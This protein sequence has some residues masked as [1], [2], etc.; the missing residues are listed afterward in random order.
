MSESNVEKS[1]EQIARELAEFKKAVQEIQD[2]IAPFQAQKDEIRDSITEKRKEI[3]ALNRKSLGIDVKVK[4]SKDRIKKIEF[5]IRR[6]E[7]DFNR[8]IQN[9]AIRAEFER[10]KSEFEDV[11]AGA[12]WREFALK[13]Q[14]DGGMHLAAAKRGILGDKPGLGKTLTSLIWADMVKAKKIIVI[15]PKDTMSNFIREVN[16]WAPHRI[17]MPI[18]GE[19]R[20]TR[21]IV[22]NMLKN[23]ENYLAL[24]NYDA[25]RRD[26]DMLDD[27]IALKADTIILDEAHNMKVASTL[28]AR[29]IRKIVLTPNACRECGGD[30]RQSEIVVGSWRTTYECVA[31]GH[32]STEAYEMSSIRNVL[33]M[34]GTPI[35]NRPQDLFPMLNIVDPTQFPTEK[36]FLENYCYMIG[37]NKWDFKY[38][39]QERLVKKLATQFL[40]RTRHDAGIVLP[41]QDV[42]THTIQFDHNAYPKQSQILRDLNTAAQIALDDETAYGFLYIIEL[43]LRKRQALVWPDGIRLKN[44]KT[45]EVIFQVDVKESIKIDYMISFDKESGEWQGLIPD[46]VGWSET[47]THKSMMRDGE[48]IVAFSQF[49]EPMHEVRRRCEAAGISVVEFNGETPPAIAE[50]VKIDID[51][52]YAH[53]DGR[54]PKYQVILAHYRKGGEGLNMTDVSQ[55]I[56]LDAPWNPAGEEQAQN[57][58]DRMGQ[59][60]ETTVHILEVENSIDTWMRA[61]IE[62][63]RNMINGFEREQNIQQALINA[64]RSGEIL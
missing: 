32:Q 31:C 55:M 40:V 21:N 26:A 61:I 6:K 23:Q 62:A 51:K 1:A 11:I 58:I 64:I 9:E 5:D 10:A 13:H 44:P 46:L 7:R 35:I 63:K 56:I 60:Q 38:G 8:A 37:A 14:V 52:N 39:G 49:I 42:Q 25:W 50:D 47:A 34:T 18:G 24:F 30:I 22:L 3:E 15:L 33:P 43:I 17:P 48:R 19:N 54:K 59:T 57:R 12:P 2:L 29:G 16:H 36:Q 53:K 27:I 45:K 4:A 28:R 41:P 20:N